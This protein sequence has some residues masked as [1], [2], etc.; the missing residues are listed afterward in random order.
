MTDTLPPA[1]QSTAPRW[2]RVLLVLSLALNLLV[3]GLVVGDAF[4]GGGP[5][6]GPRPAEMT[7]G[8]LARALDEDDR[9]AILR[10]LRGHPDI[11]ALGRDRRDQ[12]I[13]DIVAAFR[14]EPFDPEQ[15]RA[16]LSVQ[17]EQVGRVQAAAQQALVDRLAAMETEARRAFADRLE[18]ARGR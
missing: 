10:S 4:V 9:R 16:A 8:P 15:A 5:G 14:A 6:R 2:M 13:E 18:Q 11:E 12:G 1:S 17:A 7:L 3:A